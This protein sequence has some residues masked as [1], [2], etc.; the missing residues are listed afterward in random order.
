MLLEMDNS[1]LLHLIEHQPSLNEKVD[2]ALRVLQDWGTDG[3]AA[4]PASGEEAAAPA[5]EA[6]KEEVK[7]EK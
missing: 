4:A 1:E 3:A 5:A 2:E 6:P 7:E